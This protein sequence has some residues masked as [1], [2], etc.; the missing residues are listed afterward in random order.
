MFQMFLSSTME[1]N[2]VLNNMDK[3]III[4]IFLNTF[5][6]QK[7]ANDVSPY[8][9]V[10]AWYKAQLQ[11]AFLNPDAC[12]FTDVMLLAHHRV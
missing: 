2:G 12:D 5:Y 9:V 3:K 11:Q 7:S 4:I 10:T 1:V 8:C 6:A